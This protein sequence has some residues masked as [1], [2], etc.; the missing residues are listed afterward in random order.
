GDS[1]AAKYN[2]QQYTAFA[3]QPEARTAVRFERRLEL[4]LEGH[5]F[6]DLVRWGIAKQTIESYS[7]FEGG[8]LSAFQNIQFEPKDEYFPIPQQQIDR[9]QGALTQ[10]D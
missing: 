2:V 8:L 4:A 6:Y 10:N 3:S 7:A 5:R 1:R 9:S